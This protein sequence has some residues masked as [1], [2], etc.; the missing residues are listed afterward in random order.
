MVGP[1]HRRLSTPVLSRGGRLV[2]SDHLINQWAKDVD[3]LVYR[4]HDPV[5]PGV[6]I[7]KVVRVPSGGIAIAVTFGFKNIFGVWKRIE[8]RRLRS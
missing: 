2:F 3:V 7:R 6:V 4:F 8:N 1:R 5:S